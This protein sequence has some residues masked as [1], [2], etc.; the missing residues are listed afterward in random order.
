MHVLK[1]VPQNIIK[2]SRLVKNI[3]EGI[4]DEQYNFVGNFMYK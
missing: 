4:L 1:I 2:F 3:A